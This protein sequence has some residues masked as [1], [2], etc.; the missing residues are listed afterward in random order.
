MQWIDKVVEYLFPPKCAGCHTFGFELCEKCKEHI[1]NSYPRTVPNIYIGFSYQDP[2]IKRTIKALKFK[3]RRKLANILGELLYERIAE[4]LSDEKAFSLHQEILVIPIPLSKKRFNERGFN[5][6]EL[7][8]RSFASRDTTLLLSTN[9]LTRN[10]HTKPQ[11]SIN[12]KRER[13][14]NIQGVFSVKNS[15]LLIGKTCILIDDIVTTGATMKEA[16]SVLKKS[17]AK[18][19]ILIAVAH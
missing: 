11:S 12:L 7:I 5:Q 13:L 17:G 3:K 8:A 16:S 15:P 2:I 1:R 6:S 4:D 9:I 10:K 19:V 18:K 14:T